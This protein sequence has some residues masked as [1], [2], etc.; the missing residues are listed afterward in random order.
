MSEVKPE[1]KAEDEKSY[2]GKISQQEAGYVPLSGIA[3]QACA[4]CRWFKADWQECH[5]VQ[6]WPETIMATGHSNRWEG[7]PAP[8]VI[9]ADI[10]PVAIVDVPVQ[11]QFEEMALEIPKSLKDRA[12]GFLKALGKPPEQQPAF[13]VFKAANGKKAWVA[14]HTGKW[15][16]REG[17]ILAEAA[18]DTY[19][20]RVQSGKV[21][22]PELWMWHNK[23]TKHG[24]A[25]TVWKSGGFVLAA[26]YF[27]ET[28]AGNKAFDYYQKN[29]GKIKLSHMFHYPTAA[30]IDGVYYEINTIEITTL[31]DGAEAFPYTSF[32]EIKTMTL[33][34]AA[35]SMIVE[36]LGE[37][38]LNAALAA[39]GK[40][41]ADTKTLDAQGI[42]SKNYDKY[43]GSQVLEAAQKVGDFAAE[44]VAMKTRLEAAETTVKALE[45]LP[46][47]VLQL[48][49]QVKLLA[50]AVKNEETAKAAALEQVS[51]LEKRVAELTDMQPPASKSENTLLNGREQ[52]LVERVMTEAKSANQ[53][54]LVE[55]V[56]GAQP[57]INS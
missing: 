29:S 4:N 5:L 19:V 37:D 3:G 28:P 7:M 45:A 50:E 25:V 16:D 26:G 17:E 9:S 35:R 41:A 31:P 6:G 11:I 33:P 24:Q 10:I 56:V 22:P 21:A 23:A 39:D 55:Q 54:S 20:E 30:K 38:V 8:V 42:A 1:S 32:Q 40:A 27:D 13:Q 34:D 36:A 46:A 48:I 49:D 14:R 18:L 57:T 12:L 53:L 43:D 51:N 52:S 44:H 47:Q 15:I 2:Q